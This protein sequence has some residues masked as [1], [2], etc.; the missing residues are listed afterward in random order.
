[1]STSKTLFKILVKDQS[2]ILPVKFGQNPVRGIREKIFVGEN[3]DTCIHHIT[4]AGN[5]S[6]HSELIEAFFLFN[7]DFKLKLLN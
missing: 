1:L 5:K 7:Q 6:S 4:K 3:V 2:W